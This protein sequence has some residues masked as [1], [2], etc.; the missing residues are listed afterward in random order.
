MVN[1][2]LYGFESLDSYDEFINVLLQLR[3][4]K[5]SKGTKPV[6]LIEVLTK[7]LQ[8]LSIDDLRPL[9]DAIE[10]TNKT[11]EQILSL[12]KQ[13]ITL[14]PTLFLNLFLQIF[15]YLLS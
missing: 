4:P 1:D 12:E 7:V 13:L 6:D 15:F 14:P 3:S 5:L 10:D 2:L 8:S 11:K 9:S